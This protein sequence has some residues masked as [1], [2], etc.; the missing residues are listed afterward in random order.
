MNSDYIYQIYWPRGGPQ[1]AVRS[2]ADAAI[3]DGD[4]DGGMGSPIGN[5]NMLAML[6]QR[7]MGGEGGGGDW[8]YTREAR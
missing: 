6:Q 2:P 5:L 3:F 7:H 1:F 8:V 4:Q